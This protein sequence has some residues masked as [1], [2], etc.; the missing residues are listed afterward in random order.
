[1]LPSQSAFVVAISYSTMHLTMDTFQYVGESALVLNQ[2]CP[3]N[4]GMI[5]MANI[6]Q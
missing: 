2:F 6:E 4:F 5:A 3:Y 1:M